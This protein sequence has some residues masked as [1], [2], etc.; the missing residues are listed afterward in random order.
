MCCKAMTADCL[1]CAQGITT[2]EYCDANPQFPGCFQAKILPAALEVGRAESLGKPPKFCCMGMTADCLACSAGVSVDKYCRKHP[3]TVGCPPRM[4]CKAMTAD[5]L[6]CA[7]GITTEEYC[8]ANPQFPGC[9]QAKI[10][11]AALEVGRAESLG[12]PP[13]FC[14]MGMT[15]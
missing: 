4:C 11:P 15:A 1:A 7:Q 12:K 8:D 5:C 9:F 2:E 14:C 3:K 6:A 13:K 10:L